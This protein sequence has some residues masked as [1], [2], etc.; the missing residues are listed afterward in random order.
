MH[1]WFF[2][3]LFSSCS[4]LNSIYNNYMVYTKIKYH[5]LIYQALKSIYINEIA[6]IKV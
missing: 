3:D 5:T 4:L 6:V 2:H 1:L